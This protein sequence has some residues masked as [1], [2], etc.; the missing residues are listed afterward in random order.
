MVVKPGQKTAL[1]LHYH[2]SEHW[3]VVSGTAKIYKGG[4]E[5]I[6]TENESIYIPVGT[7]HYFENP[8]KLPLEIIEVRTGSYLA[9]DDIVRNQAQEDIY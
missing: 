9:E 1:Q 7:E 5:H 8:G 6:I 4:Q 3:I 2:R